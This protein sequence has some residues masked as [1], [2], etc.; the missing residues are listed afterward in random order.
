MRALEE[1]GRLQHSS[2]KNEMDNKTGR[3]NQPG[4]KVDEKR[5]QEIKIFS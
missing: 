5:G 3:V 1:R 2:C 4:E